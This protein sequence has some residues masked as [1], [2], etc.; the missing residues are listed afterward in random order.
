MQFTFE[1]SSLSKAFDLLYAET[2]VHTVKVIGT[3]GI[4]KFKTMQIIV[5]KHRIPG[6][7]EV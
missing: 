6:V 3:T 2:I 5:G 1:I 4:N 7:R